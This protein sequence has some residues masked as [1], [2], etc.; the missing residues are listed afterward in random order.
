M[1]VISQNGIYRTNCLITGRGRLSARMKP[2][3][4]LRI[5]LNTVFLL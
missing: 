5:I 1:A 2:M 3:T 4:F